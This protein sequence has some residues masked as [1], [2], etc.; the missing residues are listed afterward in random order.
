[1]FR[2]TFE[3][4]E[5]A[6]WKVLYLGEMSLYT[7]KM[8]GYGIFFD[9]PKGVIEMSYFKNGTSIGRGIHFIIKGGGMQYDEW[10][11][12]EN[13]DGYSIQWDGQTAYMKSELTAGKKD[14]FGF[15]REWWSTLKQGHI[16]N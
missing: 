4:I 10:I 14:G 5:I 3:P 12:D 13:G 9:K 15:K 6:D 11:V 1:M 7:G 16:K 8:H 2:D